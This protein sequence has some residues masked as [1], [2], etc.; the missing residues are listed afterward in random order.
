MTNTSFIKHTLNRAI[1]AQLFMFA[2]YNPRGQ[3]PHY[4]I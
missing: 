2:L 4:T 1:V 3:H